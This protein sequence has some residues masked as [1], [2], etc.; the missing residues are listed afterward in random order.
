MKKNSFICFLLFFLLVTFNLYSQ[1]TGDLERIR[2]TN[3]HYEPEDWTGHSMTRWVTSMAQGREFVYFGTTGG[4]TRYNY[5]MNKWE[6]PWSKSDGLADNYVITVAYDIHSD[7]LWCAT[8]STMSVYRSTFQK[9]ENY[10]FDEI[11]IPYNETVVSIG[12]DESYIWAVTQNEMYYRGDSR[13]G[14]FSR[15]NSDDVSSSNIKW[16]GSNSRNNRNLP[17][18]FMQDGYFLDPQGVIKDY[19]LNN[20]AITCN[21]QDQ[22]NNIW[23]GS[24]GLGVGKADSRIQILELM[25]QGLFLDNVTAAEMDDD[26]NI[27]VGGIGHFNNESGITLWD[28]EN[29]E[30]Q[31]FQGE[32]FADI[33][34]DQVTSIAIDYPY[35]WFG[36]EYGLVCYDRENNSWRSFSTSLGLS[37]NY[38]YDVEADDENVWIGTAYGLSRLNKSELK[39]KDFGIYD[40]VPKQIRS[41]IVYDIE[42]MHNL[43]WIGTELGIYVYDKDEKSGGFENEA[44][45]PQNNKITAI[46]CFED[47]EVWAG[48]S[49]GIA[50]FDIE[51]QKWQGGPEKQFLTSDFINYISVDNDAAWVAT[52]NG[53]LKFDKKRDRWVHFTVIDGL[54]SNQVNSIILDGDYVWFGT[55][56]GLTRF[57]WNS[58]Y[59]ID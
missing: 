58:P 56:E 2:G 47:K 14:G 25:P 18:L 5:F 30:W 33:L 4:I 10:F 54:L 53:V 8:R 28:S 42:I 15:I 34:S 31:Y 22:W 51:K 16:F 23:I 26:Y 43:L 21:F 11:G 45:G 37:D 32:Y 41:M 27:W 38:I 59:R 24:W 44:N 6:T 17:D 1:E 36:T 39:E 49:G 55:E 20:Y 12:F 13:Q 46:G 50:V 52:N 57:Y 7:Y 3:I 9:W 19:R 29:D 48:Y 35:V 40:V